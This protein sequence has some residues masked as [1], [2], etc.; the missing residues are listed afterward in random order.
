MS[1]T[2]IFK[3][4]SGFCLMLVEDSTYL[5]SVEYPGLR[6]QEVDSV[7]YVVITNLLT[8]GNHFIPVADVRDSSNAAIGGQTEA[9]VRTYIDSE[10][11][12]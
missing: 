10:M 2:K 5:E 3:N 4:D 8:E 9:E 12:K 11:A 1:V 6:F 7:N